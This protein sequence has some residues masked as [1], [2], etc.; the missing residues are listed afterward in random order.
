MNIEMHP[1]VKKVAEFM[2]SE[3]PADELLGV[4][5]A[6]AIVAPSMWGRHP[7]QEIYPLTLAHEPIARESI[8]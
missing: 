6:L 7:K 2:Q 5:A 4:V 8:I 1:S 3:L